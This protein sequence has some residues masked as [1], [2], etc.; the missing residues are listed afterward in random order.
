VDDWRLITTWGADPGFNMGLDEALLESAGSPPTLRFYT[1]RPDTLSL[2]YF[3]RYADV[4]G[5][6]RAGAVVRRITGGG[7]I[8]HV[9]ELTFSLAAS[10]DHPLYRGGVGESYAR[11]HAAIASA[12]E[13][14]GVRAAAR[15][16]AGLES[17]RAGTG[18][19][20]HVSTPLDLA[21][22]GRKGVGSAQRRRR[23]RVLHHGSIKL[24][25]SPLE[26]AIATAREHAPSITPE[27][28]A[29][30]VREAF[31]R[32]L[33]LRAIAAVP[34]EAERSAARR[35]ARRYLDPADVRRR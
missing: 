14:I 7:A 19:C 27:E 23:G 9:A 35:L 20:F 29:A 15:G 33:G 2:G 13:R 21:W 18:M 24:G 16:A 30:L 28:L 8:H 12:L 22:G 5:V 11:V 34:D 17:D 1:W 3:Q 6:E 26:G 31:A 10:L 32:E 4:P 25:S